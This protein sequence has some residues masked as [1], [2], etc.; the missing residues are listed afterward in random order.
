MHVLVLFFEGKT[1]YSTTKCQTVRTLEGEKKKQNM[2]DRN[3]TVSHLTK[4]SGRVK[5]ACIMRK[6]YDSTK[7][8]YSLFIFARIS[9][10]TFTHEDYVFHIRD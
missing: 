1:F 4:D 3:E 6:Q 10:V 8:N 5:M 2:A 9:D 7:K